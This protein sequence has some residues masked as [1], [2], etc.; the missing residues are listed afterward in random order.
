M[1]NLNSLLVVVAAVACGC[2]PTPSE[3]ASKGAAPPKPPAAM[4]PIAGPGGKLAL[5][6]SLEQAKKAFPAP[7]DARVFDTSMS[8]AILREKGWGWQTPTGQEAFEVMLRDGKV[9]AVA[10]TRA[11]APRS[12]L[13]AAIVDW[14]KATAESKGKT[15]VALSWVR[16]DSACVA[17]LMELPGISPYGIRLM[18]LKT[19]LQKLS[20]NPD[21]PAAFVKQMDAV[22]AAAKD[23]MPA[24]KEAKRKAMEKAKARREPKL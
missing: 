8:L 2:S 18:G 21:D 15:A 3:T 4:P 23:M 24:F 1:K 13:N 22:A 6:D 7:K 19:D 11:I 20:Y 12:L 16:G 9:S 5:G 10:Q 14:G 17:I